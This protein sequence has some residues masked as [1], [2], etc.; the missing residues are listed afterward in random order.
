MN[1]CKTKPL[2]T[3][4]ERLKGTEQLKKENE[5]LKQKLLLYYYTYE[6]RLVSSHAKLKVATPRQRQPSANRF[7]C[8]PTPTNAIIIWEC[9][10]AFLYKTF[11]VNMLTAEKFVGIMD[12]NYNKQPKKKNESNINGREEINNNKF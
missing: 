11:P 12:S 7:V 9:T 10:Q 6:D 3:E 5:V 2:R 8:T 4:N 1:F